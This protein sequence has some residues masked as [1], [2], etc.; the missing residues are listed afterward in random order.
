MW[1]QI[2]QQAWVRIVI[3]TLLQLINKDMFSTVFSELG[4]AAAKATKF[5]QIDDNIMKQVDESL[6]IKRK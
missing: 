3:P 1:S 6:G 4:W 5:T 2:L